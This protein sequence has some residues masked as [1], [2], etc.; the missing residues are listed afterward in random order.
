MFIVED[1]SKIREERQKNNYLL[2]ENSGFSTKHINVKALNRVCE[3]LGM[4]KEQLM[5]QSE[6]FKKLLSMQVSVNSS[7]QGTKDEGYVIDGISKY[8]NKHN[9]SLRNLGTHDKIPLQ[10]GKIL[11][12]KDCKK[13]NVPKNEQLKSFDFEG[14][15][16]NKTILGFAKIC[17]GDGG[18]QD[19]VFLETV[20]LLEWVDKHGD[21]NHL[22]I[23][24]ID[25]LNNKA[26]KKYNSLKQKYLHLKNVFIGDHQEV[27]KHLKG[28]YGS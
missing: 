4:N 16:F 20:S 3:H 10:D 27:Q 17:V 23:A 19:N 18:H 15:V 22:Y 7:R 26:T 12:R 6:Q 11:S 2:V 9:I 21:N 14:S 25:G 8:L 5:N 28:N 1:F 24:M 13:L